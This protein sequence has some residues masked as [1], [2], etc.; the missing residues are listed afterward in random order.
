MKKLLVFLLIALVLCPAALPAQ[1][2][3]LPGSVEQPLTTS[4]FWQRYPYYQPITGDLYTNSSYTQGWSMGTYLSTAGCVPD[5]TPAIAPVYS[6][7]STASQLLFYLPENT[8]LN[9]LGEYD[10]R[11]YDGNNDMWLLAYIPDHDRYGWIPFAA[12][13]AS[14]PCIDSPQEDVILWGYTI[15]RLSTR[16]GPGTTY[17]ETGSYNST[18]NTWVQVRSRAWDAVN[19]IWWVEVLIGDQWLWTGYK[20]F[21][22]DSLPLESIPLSTTYSNSGSSSSSGGSYT[23]PASV[24]SALYGYAI[25]RLSTRSGP[26]TTYSETGSYNSTKNT[27]VQVRSRAWDAESDTWWVEVL[28]GDQWLWTGY[29]RFDPDSLPLESIPISR[30]Y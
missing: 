16:S 23:P 26:G 30:N 15:Q 20:R 25:Q 8:T 22:P 2:Q 17:S 13:A 14:G 24:S 29:K 10:G 27:W 6:E 5:F 19:E 3:S 28:I 11:L 9:V 1:A 12:L 18:K 7:A 4:D 21:D